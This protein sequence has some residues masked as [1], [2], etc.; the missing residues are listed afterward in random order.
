MHVAFY[1]GRK[2]LFNR[3][4][5]WYLRGPYSHCELVLEARNGMSFCAS[6]SFLDGG[7]RVKW[8]A[9]DPEHWDIIPVVGSPV[10]ATM[11]AMEHE[12]DGYDLRGLLGFVWRRVGE[13]RGKWFCNEAVGAMLGFPDSW[14]FDPMSFWAALVAANTQLPTQTTTTTTKTTEDPTDA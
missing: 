3:L 14:R 9:L 7:V 11:W 1:K 12:E 5:S 2:R 13:E 8:I 4:V 6:S 10:A